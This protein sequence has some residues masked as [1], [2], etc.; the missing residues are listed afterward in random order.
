MISLV[1]ETDPLFP[2]QAGAHLLSLTS[3]V[4]SDDSQWKARR[5]K[6]SSAGRE[7]E[8]EPLSVTSAGAEKI[9]Q[10]FS[11]VCTAQHKEVCQEKSVSQRGPGSPRY[12]PVN[13]FPG[14]KAY[15]LQIQNRR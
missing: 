6:G 9:K 1:L 15:I 3:A 11:T 2:Y 14:P 13:I 5:F 4:L 10:I 8:G 12:D 7:S